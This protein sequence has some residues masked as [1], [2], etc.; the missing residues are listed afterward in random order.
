LIS[1]TMTRRKRVR[2]AS[3][4]SSAHNDT[5]FSAPS[6]PRPSLDRDAPDSKKSKFEKRYRTDITS[7]EDVLS[8]LRINDFQLR[9]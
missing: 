3:V 4:S 8:K 2:T 6:S 1:L 9:D 5:G 7:D